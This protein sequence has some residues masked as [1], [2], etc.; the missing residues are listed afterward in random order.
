[1]FGHAGRYRD[2]IGE[3]SRFAAVTRGGPPGEHCK[4][5]ISLALAWFMYG[6]HLRG[7]CRLRR[8]GRLLRRHGL[9]DDDMATTFAEAKLVM[10]MRM[11]QVARWTRMGWLLR[12]VQRECAGIYEPALRYLQRVGAWDRLQALQHNAERIGIARTDQLPLPAR[13]GYD[14][15]GLVSMEVIAARDQMR[16][17]PWRLSQERI[18]EGEK[19]IDA[20]DRYGWTAE[21][22][23]LH[24][25]LAWRGDICDAWPH[26]RQAW[27]GF[28]KTQYSLGA[29][30]LQPLHSVLPQR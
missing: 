3:L 17:P 18:A 7:V 15:L 11:A 14:C 30:L 5:E 6:A 16:K 29:R 1:M 22:W 19:G 4:A 2:V 21:E 27:R 10:M 12:W 13:K 9:T 8:A 20:S 28:W 25:I 26:L 23:K 24:W